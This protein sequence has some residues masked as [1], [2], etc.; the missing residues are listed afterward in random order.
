MGKIKNTL[1]NAPARLFKA[2]DSSKLRKS[3]PVQLAAIDSR[4]R[5]AWAAT[6]PFAATY[7]LLAFNQLLPLLL[8]QSKFGFQ[9]LATTRK[10][11]LGVLKL[12]R[13]K[14]LAVVVRAKLETETESNKSPCLNEKRKF[15]VVWLVRTRK[16]FSVCDE[17]P[18]ARRRSAS[19]SRAELVGR[20]DDS[21]VGGGGAFAPLLVAPRRWRR[22]WRRYRG[23]S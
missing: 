1:G 18:T 20:L 17:Q 23:S 6:R 15:P 13:K 16:F 3:A 19:Y 14:E 2:P 12:D 11:G 22:V 5:F 7:L 10:P 9:S 8:L 21:R 4:T